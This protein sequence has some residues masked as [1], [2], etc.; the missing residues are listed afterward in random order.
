MIEE[1]NG[2]IDGLGPHPDKFAAP[3]FEL[4][5]SARSTG[6]GL[7]KIGTPIWIFIVLIL[8][9]II[10]CANATNNI[11]ASNDASKDSADILVQ[12]SSVVSS[13]VVLNVDARAQKYIKGAIHIDYRE[14]SDESGRPRAVS[15]LAKILGDAGISRS[16]SVVVY[17]VNPS[18]ASYICLILSYL[19]QERVK[20]LDGGIDSWATA[21]KPVD[22]SPE[23]KP[24]ATYTPLPKNDLI[25][26]YSYLKGKS[27][28]VVDARPAQ[29]FAIG[30]ITGSTNVP[31]GAVIDGGRIKGA[32]ALG[33][34]FSGLSKDKPVAVYSDPGIDAT[35][36]WFA[37]EQE[38]YDAHFYAGDDWSAGLLKNKP[39]TKS[40][41]TPAASGGSADSRPPCCRV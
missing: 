29:E 41:G 33:D 12:P 1:I 6:S 30:S 9:S 10:T 19:G 34:I 25:V 26:P 22:K 31:Y 4:K 7:P 16:D 15:E 5:N 2:Y 18:V 8:A 35:V 20:L 21:G 27:I 39:S 40:T 37:L 3:K 32:V 28:Q 38:G 14:F 23:L 11:A 24:G 17:S 36:V 13:D